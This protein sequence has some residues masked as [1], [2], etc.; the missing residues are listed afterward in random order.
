MVTNGSIG[1]VFIGHQM[2]TFINKSIHLRKKLRY[3]IT[4]HRCGPDRAA[5]FNRHQYSLFVGAFAPFVGNP[6]FITRFAADVFFVQ[7]DNTAKCRNQFICGIHHLAHRMAYFP[8]AFLGGANPFSQN[9][10]GYALG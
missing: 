10:R 7:L 3:L 9:N 1:M 8:G 2:R 5:A 4:G 6:F